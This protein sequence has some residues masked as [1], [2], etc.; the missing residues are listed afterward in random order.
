MFQNFHLRNKIIFQTIQKWKTLL[1]VYAVDD[2]LRD[3][4]VGKKDEKS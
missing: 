1:P 2:I 3:I 4:L